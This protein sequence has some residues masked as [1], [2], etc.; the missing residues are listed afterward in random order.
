MEQCGGNSQDLVA[1]EN[2]PLRR[3]FFGDREREFFYR[4]VVA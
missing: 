1:F 3:F 2:R 4:D